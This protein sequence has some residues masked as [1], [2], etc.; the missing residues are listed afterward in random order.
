M[1]IQ[2]SKNVH[3]AL[4]KKVSKKTR[5]AWRKHIHIQGLDEH[6]EKE[7]FEERT[8]D[9]SKKQNDELFFVDSKADDKLIDVY[10]N[11]ADKRLALRNSELKHCAVLT[12][13]YT[14]VPDPIIKRNRVKTPEERKNPIT[15]NNLLKKKINGTL[16]KTEKEALKNRG[17]TEL[18]KKNRYKRGDFLTDVWNDDDKNNKPSLNGETIDC[19][20]FNSDTLRHIKPTKKSK[21]VKTTAINKIAAVEPP[22]PGTSYNPSWDDHQQLLHTIAQ[23][24]LKLIKEEKHLNRVTD[25]M[26]RKVTDEAK[27]T[28]WLKESSEGLPVSKGGIKSESEEEVDKYPGEVHSI[29]PPAKLKKKTKQQRRKQREQKLLALKLKNAKIEKKK[30]G[31]IYKLRKMKTKIET[32]EIEDEKTRKLRLAKEEKKLLTEPVKLSKTK[33]EAPDIDFKMGEDLT[34]NLRN[35]DP[36]GNLLRDRYKSLQKRSIVAPSTRSFKLNKARVKKFIKADHKI[37]MPNKKQKQ[38]KK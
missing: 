35:A 3:K 16:T 21:R 17:I 15:K 37:E 8:G 5:K 28:N 11:K 30:I 22:H 18:N 36:T 9:F 33:F 4:R 6:L 34:G 25:K 19:E 38:S 13:T 20:W 1:A 32:K 14:A 29:N 7:R 12:S 23:E 27:E 31:D 10:E 24:E 2:V 26:F